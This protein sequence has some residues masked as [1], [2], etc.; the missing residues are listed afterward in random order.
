MHCM[1]YLLIVCAAVLSVQDYGE[2]AELFGPRG[3]NYRQHIRWFT[4]LFA[5]PFAQFEPLDRLPFTFAYYTFAADD[6]LRLGEPIRLF[7]PQEHVSYVATLEDSVPTPH[8]ISEAEAVAIATQYV[9]AH[10]PELDV[11]RRAPVASFSQGSFGFW[12][13]EA[14]GWCVRFG[15]PSPAGYSRPIISHIIQMDQY[16]RVVSSPMT[17]SP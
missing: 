15:I 12:S 5:G 16:G 11:S 7:G 17:M 3:P 10:E 8:P 2:A 1:K 13:T 4:T 9:H 14:G 6:F